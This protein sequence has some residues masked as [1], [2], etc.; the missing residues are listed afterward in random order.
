MKRVV[1]SDIHTPRQRGGQ[2]PRAVPV[3]ELRPDIPKPR[4]NTRRG[5][6]TQADV[7]RMVAICHRSASRTLSG[8]HVDARPVWVRCGRCEGLGSVHRCAGAWGQRVAKH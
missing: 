1:L 7:Y 3:G 4:D 8:A 2:D 6:S 5:G